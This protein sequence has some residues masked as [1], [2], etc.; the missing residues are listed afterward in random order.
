MRNTVVPISMAENRLLNAQGGIKAD[1]A[2]AFMLSVFAKFLLG[3][4]DAE[5]LS[6]QDSILKQLFLL[7]VF[8]AF[9]LFCHFFECCAA[10]DI[11]IMIPN[12]FDCTL[13][14]HSIFPCFS[15]S[16]LQI[17]H[18]ISFKEFYPIVLTVTL[19]SCLTMVFRLGLLLVTSSRQ[20]R[21]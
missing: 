3:F 1:S 5:P 18:N 15:R 8:S 19:E 17:I 13:V 20:S 21:F 7:L 6:G 14:R 10:H 4:F 9:N 2:F 11:S 16:L 12:E